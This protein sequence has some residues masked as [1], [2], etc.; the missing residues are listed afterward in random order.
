MPPGAVAVADHVVE[1]FG[2]AV[3]LVGVDGDELPRGEGSSEAAQV[4]DGG[5]ARGVDV[6]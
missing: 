6:G 3:A 2:V 1:E 5:V 4:G